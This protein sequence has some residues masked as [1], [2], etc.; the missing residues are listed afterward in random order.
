MEDNVILKLKDGVKLIEQDGRLGF[1]LDG[2]TQFAKNED[3]EII[4]KELAKQP[5]SLE[6][7]Y[8][9][10]C[11][12]SGKTFRYTDASLALAEFILDLDYYIEI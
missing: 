2:H 5:Q 6:K 11:L 10:L 12:K 9:W 7:L 8:A 4:L 1:S 3:Q